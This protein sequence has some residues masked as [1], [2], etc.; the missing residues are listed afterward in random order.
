MHGLTGGSGKRSAAPATDAEKN[1]PDGKP[2]GAHGS[3][4]YRRSTPPR[5]LPTL[6]QQSTPSQSV[7]LAPLMRAAARRQGLLLRLLGAGSR[8]AAFG[9]SLAQE[10]D[11]QRCVSQVSAEGGSW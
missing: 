6:H 10:S 9:T 11:L 1:N 8:P 5:Q 3:T 7:R 4:T 2:R